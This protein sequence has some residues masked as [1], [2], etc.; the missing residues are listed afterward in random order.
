MDRTK[1]KGVRQHRSREPDEAIFPAQESSLSSP[2]CG[3]LHIQ[4]HGSGG[5]LELELRA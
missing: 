4:A 1:R 2:G 3:E 5:C